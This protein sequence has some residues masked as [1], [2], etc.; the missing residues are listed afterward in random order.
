MLIGYVL[1]LPE[2]YIKCNSFTQKYQRKLE[3]YRH[4]WI[5]PLI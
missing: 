1:I 4:F 3:K 5:Y 2:I